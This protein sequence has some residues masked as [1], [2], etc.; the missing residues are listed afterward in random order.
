MN[1]TTS[2]KIKA[3]RIVNKEQTAGWVRVGELDIRA[4]KNATT[5]ITYKVMKTDRWTVAQNTK[6]TSLY[7]GDDDTYVWYDPDGSANST[8][9]DVMVDDFLGYDLGTEAVLD[10]AHIV[11]GHDGGDKIVKYAVDTSVD[12]K[13]WTPVKGY[14]SH[15]GAATGKDVLDIDLNGVTARYIRIRNLEQK[16]SWA[17]FSEFTVE[18][19]ISQAGTIENIYTNVENHGMVGQVE[20]GVS[21]LQPGT[22]SL[23]KV[24]ILVLT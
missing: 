5:P 13:T 1:F 7:D 20:E 19:R 24:N 23:E 8:N 3:I 11:V 22:I 2:E 6:E 9:D 14:E 10:K 12:N 18:Q 15:T 21:S 16:G 17:K 4:S